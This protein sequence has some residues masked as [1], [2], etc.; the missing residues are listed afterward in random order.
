[1]SSITTRALQRRRRAVAG[2]LWGLGI[3]VGAQL[4]LCQ[5]LESPTFVLAD[6]EYQLKLTYLKARLKKRPAGAPLVLALGSSRFGVG[7]CPDAVASVSS[8]AG[9]QPL[10]FNFALCRSNPVMELVCLRRLLADGIRPDCV[11]IELYPLFFNQAGLGD[12]DH[13]KDWVCKRFQT[14]D[15]PLLA[16]YHPQFRDI[17]DRWQA[18]RLLPVYS[19]RDL[20]LDRWLPQWE[21]RLHGLE[22]QFVDEWG[23]LDYPRWQGIPRAIRQQHI[24]AT[25]AG[26]AHQVTRF[27]PQEASH[28]ALLEMCDLC[29]RKGIKA[30]FVLFPDTL[31]PIYS[32]EYTDQSAAYIAQ[33]S[34]MVSVPVIDLSQQCSEDD[35][36]DC[37][38]MEP[39]AA[40]RFTAWFEREV[41][42]PFLANT[43]DVLKIRDPARLPAPSDVGFKSKSQ[44]ETRWLLAGSAVRG[45]RPARLPEHRAD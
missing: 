15:W 29:R 26:Y 3:L 11:L 33:L 1:M 27:A 36:R 8:D 6:P 14:R 10:L 38:H 34:E 4:V 21:P 42:E 7:I 31:G 43:E 40:R 13:I 9:F 44:R 22:W 2:L 37:Q 20:V 35:F 24:E 28:R 18:D 41:L 12:H 25:R 19:H 17:H 5:A 30:A 23:W 16:R 45:V 32:A 39:A